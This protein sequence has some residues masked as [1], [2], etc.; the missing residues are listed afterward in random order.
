MNSNFETGN[1]HRPELVDLKDDREPELVD[2]AVEATPYDADAV[3]S[4]IFSR[5]L[6]CLTTFLRA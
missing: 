5:V 2:L 4:F 6:R 1:S 3:V